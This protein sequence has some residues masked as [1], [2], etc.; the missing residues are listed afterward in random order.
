MTDQISRP[1]FGQPVTCKTALKRVTKFRPG[2]RDYYRKW[3]RTGYPEFTGLYTGPRTLQNGM[4]YLI[5]EEEGYA[6]I[7]D[8]K[9]LVYIVV[10]N[11]RTN[12]VYVLREDCQWETE[13]LIPETLI[14]VT[15][16]MIDEWIGGGE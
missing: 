1:E 7:P 13:I 10:P 5:G 3:V 16:A 2:T 8:E 9:V 6:L 4:L 12:Q 15:D 11:S 14:T